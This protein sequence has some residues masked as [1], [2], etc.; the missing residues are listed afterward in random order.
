MAL[1]FLGHAPPSSA[2]AE[3]VGAGDPQGTGRIPWKV[4]VAMVQPL[5]V[6]PPDHRAV[7]LLE[8]FREVASGGQ[9]I[10]AEDLWRASKL[11]CGDGHVLEEVLL[12][13][14]AVSGDELTERR[15]DYNEIVRNLMPDA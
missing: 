5:L 3:L 12:N 6:R 10:S 8:T 4:F 13:A 1:Q 7:A 14:E 2:L 9:W 11:G 15:F